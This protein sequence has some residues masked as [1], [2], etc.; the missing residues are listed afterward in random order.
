MP[1]LRLQLDE[2]THHCLK[3]A[4]A[5]RRK[6]FTKLLPEIVDEWLTHEK[7]TGDGDQLLGPDGAES[8]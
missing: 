4:A 7:P 8:R 6:P 2:Q 1:E 3:I 5:R